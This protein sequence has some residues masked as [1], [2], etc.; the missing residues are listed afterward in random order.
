MS[1]RPTYAVVR[2]IKK[3]KRKKGNERKAS[4]NESTNRTDTYG[5]KGVKN[6]IAHY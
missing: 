5:R 3:L 4:G 6:P 1:S 2:G